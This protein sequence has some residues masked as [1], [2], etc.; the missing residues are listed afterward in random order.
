M[1]SR[2]AS[3][4]LPKQRSAVSNGS[5]L[6]VEPPGDTKWARRWSDI[7]YALTR[8]LDP[9]GDRLTESQRHELRCA[10]SL[11]CECENME[12]TW[13]A[14]DPVDIRA[15]VLATGQ[16][17]RTFQRLGLKYERKP[18]DITDS[19]DRATKRRREAL[20]DEVTP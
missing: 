15:Y 4:K 12:G 14:G 3:E 13:A 17:G 6:H 16:L 7:L 10:A 5:R 2:I 18:L 19:I 9:T 11:C 8:E 20:W 1:A